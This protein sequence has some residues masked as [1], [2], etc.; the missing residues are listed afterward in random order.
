M[1]DRI[2]ID[3]AVCHGKPCIR[4]TRIMVTSILQLLASG[5]DFARICREY[6]ELTKKDIQAA[7]DYTASEGQVAEID[8]VYEY[9]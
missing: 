1:H 3:Q 9:K 5:Y 7:V 4:N 8:F 2:T 6:P